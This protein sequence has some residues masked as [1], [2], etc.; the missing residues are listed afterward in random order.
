MSLAKKIW[1]KI[2]PLEMN[3]AVHGSVQIRTANGTSQLAHV[4]EVAADTSGVEEVPNKRLEINGETSNQNQMSEEQLA[5]ME[6]NRL[7]ALE[8]AAARSRSMRA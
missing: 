7:K 3:H 1:N 5:R 4:G 2:L 8:R 6:A